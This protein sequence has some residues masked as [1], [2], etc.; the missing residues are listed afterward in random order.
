MNLP[1]LIQKITGEFTFTGLYSFEFIEKNGN[2]ITEVFFMTPPEN[3]SV[4]EPTRSSTM[5]TLGGNYNLDAGNA[6][7][8]VNLSGKLYFPYIGSPD[9]PVAR[10]NDNLQNRLSGLEEFLKLRWMLIRYKD[11]TLTRNAKMTVP[12][13]VMSVS[14]EITRLYKN[15]SKKVSNK[16]GALMDEIQLV[17]HDYDM[18]DHF[19]C[20]VD[21]FSGT[22]S[23]ANHIAVDYS[24]SLECYEPYTAQ[25]NTS[26]QV[27]QTTNESVDVINKEITQINFSASFDD[28]QAEIGYNSE[29]LASSTTIETTID[30][31][32]TE[33]QNIQAGSSTA[34]TLLPTYVSTLL[35]NV[36]LSLNFFID[37]FLSAEQQTLYESGDVTIDDLISQDLLDFYNILQKIKL[38]A[39][40]LNGV[41]VAI[42]V[43]DD[44]RYSQNSD[45][46][47]LT[48][49]QFDDDDSSKVE[50][51]TNF[52]YYTV[53]E[54]D[55]A[56]II[57]LRELKDESKFVS[58]LNIN[59][60][61]ENDFIDNAIVG[62]RIK[63]P[64]ISSIV[65]R[66]EDNLVFE[67]DLTNIDLYL[68]GSDIATGINDELLISSTGDILSQDGIENAFDNV[69]NRID[70][71][72]GSLNVYNPNWGSIAI[73]DSNAPLMVKIDRYLTDLI[74]QMQADPRVESVQMDLDKLEWDGER[75][76]VPSKVF[77]IGNEEPR[78]VTV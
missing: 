41:L 54:G 26:P 49:E 28:I 6:T 57:A 4:E 20:R 11:Y 38:Q 34:T 62:T 24:I 40:S 46:Y 68:Y 7:K 77:F 36:N 17:F 42:P 63:I 5:P 72:K 43:L 47:T 37:T 66:G 52:Y 65:A 13:T 35:T 67:A 32:S 69:E 58:I 51:N 78:E 19:Y 75:I 14:K 39:E 9:N 12:T 10:N 59:D 25:N 27:K 55:T 33:N 60:I 53:L 74:E 76:S 18:D 16:M 73:D 30:N 44:I 48:E 21:S 61:T 70:N 71:L 8:N 50:N 22:Q 29:F 31:I 1:T 2:T 3:K 23:A 45:D 64:I 56:R 15:I